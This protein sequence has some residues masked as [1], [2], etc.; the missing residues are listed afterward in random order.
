[1]YIHGLPLILTLQRVQGRKRPQKFCITFRDARF[2][3]APRPIFLK[4]GQKAR[5][6]LMLAFTTIYR[7]S[8][9][10]HSSSFYSTHTFFL[11]PLYISPSLI[12]EK[13]Y[14]GVLH[15]VVFTQSE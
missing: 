15:D 6:N 8:F 14:I 10:D 4:L 12:I 3:T 7:D 9:T 1:M 5:M 11:T 2:S 13:T